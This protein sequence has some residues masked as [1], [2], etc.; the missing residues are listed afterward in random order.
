MADVI[1]RAG[2]RPTGVRRDHMLICAGLLLAAALFMFVDRVTPPIILW[3]ESRL[4]VNAL[5]MHQRGWSLVTT[6]G[7]APDLWNT[8]PP[9]MIWLMTASMDLFGPTELALRLPSML[10]ALG[11]LALVYAF[12][13][14]TTKSIATAVLAVVLLATSVGFYGEHGART[15]DYDSL[16]CFFVTAYL[17]LFYRAVH[18]RRPGW[19]LLLLAAALVAGATMTKTIAGLVPGAGVALYLLVSGR[20]PRV[21]GTL[22]YPAILLLALVPVGTFYTVREQ[23]APGYLDAVWYNDFAGR[24]EVQQGLSATPPWYYFEILFYDGLFSAGILA[25][26]APLGLA[27]A[28]GQQRQALIFALCCVLAQLVIVSIAATR[29]VQYILP[30]LPW[31]AIACAIT[32]KQR[33][34]RFLGR[35]EPAPPSRIRLALAAALIVAALINIGARTATVRYDLLLQRAYYPQASYSTVLAALHDRGVRQVAVLEPG[36]R[37]DGLKGYAPQLRFYTLLWSQRGMRIERYKALPERRGVTV[38]ASC[39]PRL[40]EALLAG[41]G[42]PIGVPGCAA[43]LPRSIAKRAS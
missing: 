32:I 36:M 28:K 42:T 12:V 20:L 19:T 26:I 30:A 16:L 4:A 15:A 25:L 24:V 17:M 2:S 35:G 40:S 18:R 22:R 43:S 9:L 13:H 29:L 14:R 6:Y 37:W 5:E 34:P 3:D 7:F 41:G 21:L 31:L 39:D 27:G 38:E 11:T 10:A 33:L 23:L 8:K 1:R